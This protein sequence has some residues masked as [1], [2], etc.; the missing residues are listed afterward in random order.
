VIP[1]VLQAE[2]AN[3]DIN[4]R[5]PGQRFLNLT[6]NPT[7]KQW[8]H[9][10]FWR[11]SIQ[12]LRQAYGGICA[13]CAEW[14]PPS[15]GEWSVDHFIPKSICPASAYEWSNF[16]FVAARYNNFKGDFTDVLDPFSIQSEWFILDFTS[17][18]VLPNDNLGEEDNRAVQRTI[19]RLH[20]NDQRAIDSRL[21]WID[22]YSNNFINFEFLSQN[23]PFIAYELERQNLRE[24]IIAI[25]QNGN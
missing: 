1:V 14:I 16:R 17:F 6:P 12:D 25:A 10:S 9:N 2:P 4:V 8:K 21:R 23:A 3:F 15:T 18:Q 19:D 20:L 11:S 22:N 5:K 13:Y 7:N 24:E